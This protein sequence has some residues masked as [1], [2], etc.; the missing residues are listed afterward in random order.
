MRRFF[1]ILSLALVTVACA[2]K[3]EEVADTASDWTRDAVVY[4]LNTRQ[5]TPEGTF[6]AAEEILPRL[7]EMGVDVVWVMPL[8]PIGVEG[9][10][11][12][13][14][15]YYAIKDYNA[16]NPEFGTLEDFD[17]FLATAHGLGLKVIIDWVANHTSPDHPWVT[18]KP[19]DWYVRGADGKTIV[20]YDWTDIAKLNYD[21][22][23]VRSAMKDAMRFWL[24]RGIDGFRCD[25]A[26]KVPRDFWTDAIASFRNDYDRRLYFLAEGEE[27]WLHEAGFD[28][29]YSWKL[30]H[31]LNDIAQG[32]AGADSL[33]RYIEWNAKEY[34][35]NSERLAFTSNHDE[36][37]WAGTEFSRM[38]DAVKAMTVLCW[39]LPNTQPLIYTGQEIG[40]DH[41]FAFFE[42]D[43]IPAWKSN[44][45]TDFYAYLAD[46]KHSHPALASGKGDF[47]LLSTE[48]NSIKFRRS[49][50]DDAVTVSVS[51]QAPWDWSVSSEAD[52][53]SRVEPPCWWVGMKTPLQLLVNGEGIGEYGVT[54]EGGSGVTVTGVH[55]AESPNYLFVDVNVAAD[56]APGTYKL[57]FTKGG[58]SFKVP[59][60]IGARREGSADRESFGT[61]D[62]IY[63]IMPDRFANGDPSNDN[64]SDTREK[65]DYQAFFGR[66]GGDIQGIEDH[67]DYISDLG[68]TAIWC[69]PLLEDDEP[70]SSYHGYACTDYYNIDSR[71]GS[72]RKYR[73]FVAEAH[74]RG[75]K[76]IMDVVTNHCGDKHWWMEDLPFADWV[77]QWP[78]YTHSNCAF[79]AQNDP[80]C[81]VLDRTNMEGG[82]FD[83]SMADMNL[84]NPFTLRYFQQ[85]AAW[86]IEWADLDGLRVDTYPYNEK[87]PM[88]RWCASVREEYPGMNIVGE[89]WSVNVP[90]VAY[91]QD[92]NPN[93]DGFDSN[94]PSIMDFCLQ[95]AICQ[96][97]NTDK[98]SWDNGITKVYDSMANDVYFKDVRNMMIFPGNHDTDRI[99]DVVGKDP[100]KMKIVMTLMATL[101]GYP[102]VFAG[103]EMMVVSRDRSQGHGGLRVE[104]PEDWASDPVQKDLHDYVR[105][106]F[107]WRKTS[108]AVQNGKTLHFLTRDN[109]YAYF[110]YNDAEAVFVYVNNNA[111]PRELPWSDYA[112]IAT[113]LKGSGKYVLTGADFNPDGLS[114]PA[115]STLI[116]EFK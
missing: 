85:W 37:S 54:I 66:H 75:I 17:H 83:T 74:K 68:F 51:L 112:E 21:N 7:S 67:L 77:H 38:G 53:V 41:S 26:Y 106:L 48:N 10:K 27:T 57:V 44:S 92:D 3:V 13:L 84:D 89:V 61:A 82:W 76:V 42:K 70:E 107:Q 46:L 6:A 100:R 19:A 72:N 110:R 55:A 71:F 45:Y 81:S 104:F 24:D 28:A 5:L 40:F 94:L 88:S 39:T 29:T 20:E 12:S 56:A 95:A 11:G 30:H 90:Q 52:K 18:E 97:I 25:V 50:G 4:E 98:E 22:E 108:D 64:T 2:P 65:A 1:A 73:E 86:W 31:L 33:V 49:L 91:W 32:K 99:G 9:R 34:P 35:A 105:A 115:K 14:G 114:V 103:D 36:N 47:E 96:G 62:A 113:S 116:V 69:T 63:L 78:E 15:S 111:E 87:E 80:Y 79:S 43:P 59:Y 102:Q 93:K 60:E 109:T 58:D 16:V 101:R 8:Y 23:D